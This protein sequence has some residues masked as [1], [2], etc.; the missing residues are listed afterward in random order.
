M[1]SDTFQWPCLSIEQVFSLRGTVIFEILP[2]RIVE[3]ADINLKIL[4]TATSF[5]EGDLFFFTQEWN[6]KN[7][8]LMQ[9]F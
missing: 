4:Q 7:N 6:S 8:I 9:Y 3:Y 5:W 1:S 2:S